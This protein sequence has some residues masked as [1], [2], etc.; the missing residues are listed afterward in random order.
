MVELHAV[1]TLEYVGN[2]KQR[3]VGHV[4]MAY[5]KTWDLFDPLVIAAMAAMVHPWC[6]DMLHIE[7]DWQDN[8]LELR[9]WW[10]NG[11]A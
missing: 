8:C 5:S 3:V 10:K 11:E 7:V 4:K 2:D 1:Y 9:V 6:E